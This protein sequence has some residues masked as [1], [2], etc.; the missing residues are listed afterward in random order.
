MKKRPT[1]LTLAA[2]AVAGVASAPSLHS[3]SA[4]K[5]AAPK[6]ARYGSS[7]VSTVRG[8]RTDRDSFTCRG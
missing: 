6:A 1:L 2:I 3:A 5:P 8:S 4:Q 7:E